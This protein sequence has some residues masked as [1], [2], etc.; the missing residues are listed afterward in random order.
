[1]VVPDEEPEEEPEEAVELPDVPF[2]PPEP[3]DDAGDWAHGTFEAQSYTSIDADE[4][5]SLRY[6]QM[7]HCPGGPPLKLEIFPQPQHL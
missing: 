7:G 3:E 5:T 4:D 2:V 6:P 1:L